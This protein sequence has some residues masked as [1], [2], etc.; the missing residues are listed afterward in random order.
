MKSNFII[1][2]GDPTVAATQSQQPPETEAL[3][4]FTTETSSILVYAENSVSAKNVHCV[5][6]LKYRFIYLFD[7]CIKFYSR[8][9]L[10]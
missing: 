6:V 10:V 1:C 7:W 8:I 4:L 9:C 2:L 5:H 3:F